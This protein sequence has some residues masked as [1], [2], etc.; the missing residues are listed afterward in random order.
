MSFIKNRKI[1]II[2]S[3]SICTILVFILALNII[4]TD[5]QDAQGSIPVISYSQKPGDPPSSLP[6]EQIQKSDAND[7]KTPTYKAPEAE[8]LN[9]R[10]EIVETSPKQTEIRQK[11]ETENVFFALGAPNDPNYSTSWALQR[12]NALP[13]WNT[14]TG[15]DSVV[16]AVID[17]GFGLNHEDLINSWHI[18]QNEI[19]NTAEGDACY[20]GSPKN[21]STN[22]CDDDNNGYIDDW[23]GWN[24]YIGDNN[25]QAG[26]INPNASSVAHGTQVAGLVG[27]KGNNSKGIATIAWD[28]S[29]MPLQALSDSGSGWTSDIAAAIYYAVDNGADVINLSLGSF[30]NDS[31]ISDAVSYAY[32]NNVVVVAAAGN[33]GTGTES[34]CTSYPAGKMLYPALSD[35]VIAVGASNFDNQRASFSSYGQRLD[36]VAPGS[37]TIVSPTWTNS[38]GTTLYAA[39]LYGTSFASPYVASLVSLI[40]AIR[41]SS[42]VDDIRAIIMATSN[43]LSA[44]NGSYYTNEYGHGIINSELAVTVASSLNSNTQK[45]TLLQAG[46]EYSERSFRTTSTM[47]SGCQINSNFYCAIKIYNEVNKLERYLTYQTASSNLRGWSW[48]GSIL[49]QDSW[50]VYAVSGENVSDKYSFSAK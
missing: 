34:G 32:D 40:K 22:N 5:K 47:A 27:A 33:C 48:G 46:S 10:P 14:T 37:G 43:K 20:D 3:A 1:A 35:H 31:F 30:V 17:G 6:Q 19:G 18:N 24:F 16:V 50:D 42:S 12:V 4:N 36:I 8:V 15:S 29:I 38:N 7:V 11:V 28:N 21:K 9:S 49:T 44:M 39:E 2:L 13:A 23:R 25:P 41:P 26:R 45:P